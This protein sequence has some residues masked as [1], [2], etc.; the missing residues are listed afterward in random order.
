MNLPFF[1]AKRI[2]F[3]KQKAF[4]GFIIRLALG[5]TALSVTVMIVALSF[6]NGFQEVISQKIFSF[7]GHIRVQQQLDNRVNIAEEIPVYQND[8]V[9]TYLQRLP[10]IASVERYATK[11]AIIKYQSGIESVLLKGIDSSFRF[12]RMQGFLRNGKWLSFG[13]STYSKQINISAH[14]ARQLHINTGDSILVFFFRSDGSKTA[15]KLV[16]SGIFKT[17]IDEYDKNFALC[18]INLIRK[19]NQWAPQQIAGY[20]IYLNDYKQI[21]EVTR[22]IYDELPQLWYSRSIQE[23]YPNIFDWLHLQEEIKRMLVGV[24]MI[25]AAVNLITCLIILIL[26]RTKMIGIMKALGSSD[27][28]I[29][30]IFLYHAVYISILG[31]LIGTVVGLLL[32]WLQ[33]ATGW[34]KLNEEAYFLS[35]AGVKIVWWEVIL[36]DVSAILLCFII[37]IL[38]S[39]LVKKIKPVKAIQFQ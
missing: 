21:P 23:I 14:T 24:M 18:D 1:L 27:I 9:E 39:L 6:I 37:L 38:P 20:E 2:A 30:K 8:T 25:I 26:E 28:G 31:T 36:V 32:S 10:E 15:R 29:Q 35:E 17:G 34:I 22:K 12:S 33:Q 4:S 11:S 13:D 3:S 19:L 16:V 7:W 5:A